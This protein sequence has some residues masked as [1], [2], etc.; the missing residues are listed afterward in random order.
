MIG[1]P[2][3]DFE[4]AQESIN[5]LASRIFVGGSRLNQMTSLLLAE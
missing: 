4:W 3:S 1:W 5:Q 2:G